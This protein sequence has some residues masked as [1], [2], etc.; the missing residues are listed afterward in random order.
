MAGGGSA[1]FPGVVAGFRAYDTDDGALLD[2]VSLPAAFV[3]DVIV[4]DDA[5]WFTDT[6]QPVLFRVPIGDDGSIGTPSLV[7][8]S[9]DWVQSGGAQC[10]RDR[11]HGR[12]QAPDRGPGP[13]G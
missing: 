2:D 7:A 9:G 3:N 1:F 12:R 11:G 13:G 8:L 5:A 10:Q 6:F 4:T